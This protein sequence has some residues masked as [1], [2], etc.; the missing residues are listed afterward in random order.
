MSAPQRSASI[1]R[2]RSHSRSRSVDDPG[3]RVI[4]GWRGV[5]DVGTHCGRYRLLLLGFQAVLER[6]DRPLAPGG[7]TDLAKLREV[8]REAGIPGGEVHY[9][10][11]VGRCA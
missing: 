10:F 6:E 1:R 11:G 9:P 2:R 3:E 5:S 4:H 7:V 8:L